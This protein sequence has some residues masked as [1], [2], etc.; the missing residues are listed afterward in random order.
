VG[1]ITGVVL[2]WHL[3]FDPDELGFSIGITVGGTIQM[4]AQHLGYHAIKRHQHAKAEIAKI[5][6]EVGLEEKVDE[7]RKERDEA[8]Q[9]HVRCML[10]VFF[11]GCGIP[12]IMRISV[13][14]NNW[15][16][17]V[18]IVVSAVLDLLYS[19]IVQRRIIENSDRNKTD[20]GNH[21]VVS[22]DQIDHENVDKV[23]QND[24][25]H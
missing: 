10:A 17:Y 9:M 18:L 1:F 13:G 11:L 4:L 15:I 16:T 12:S 20:A 22:D 23:N 6:G 2:A 25:V 5:A 19:R 7:L 8:L 3:D 24:P 14:D 21:N